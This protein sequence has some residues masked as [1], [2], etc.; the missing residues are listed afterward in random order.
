M[1]GKNVSVEGLPV[2]IDISKSKSKKACIK[3]IKSGFIVKKTYYEVSFQDEAAA[4]DN[5][6]GK[7]DSL[8]AC[9]AYI[10]VVR[11][12]GYNVAPDVEVKEYG[13]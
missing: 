2:G 1:N 10:D 8:E 5:G 13:M 3:T 12:A 7:F 11:A 4:R 6:I 9:Y